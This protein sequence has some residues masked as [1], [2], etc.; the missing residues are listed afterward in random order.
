LQVSAII[1][2]H[3][4]L[5]EQTHHLFNSIAF[6]KMKV[7]A[8]LINTSRGAVIKTLDAAEAVKSQ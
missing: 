8:M 7:G 6:A 1:S 3:S 5:T 2:I 4:P